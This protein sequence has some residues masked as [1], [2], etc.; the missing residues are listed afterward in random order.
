MTKSHAKGSNFE[1]DIARELG[2]WW[3]FGED[4]D[5]FYRS[6]TSGAR[7]TVRMRKGKH[8]RGQYGDITPVIGK[9]GHQFTDLVTVELKFGYA[10]ATMF[11]IADR[12]VGAALQIWEKFITKAITGSKNSGSPYWMLITKR[13]WHS[14]WVTLPYSILAPLKYHS[15]YKVLPAPYIR[16]TLLVRD[17]MQTSMVVETIGFRFDSFKKYFH[18][19]GFVRLY[20]A[21][22]TEQATET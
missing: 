18:P 8:T 7:A 14:P 15:G 21:F 13:D 17:T 3:S 16:S 1:R 6:V 19:S 10:Y 2:L 20:N 12:R 22:K 11:D 4:D 5:V 9:S